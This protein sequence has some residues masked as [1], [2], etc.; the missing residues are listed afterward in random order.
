MCKSN[1]MKCVRRYKCMQKLL[2][3]K[4]RISLSV[5]AVSNANSILFATLIASAGALASKNDTQ[6]TLA[7][8]SDTLLF[9]MQLALKLKFSENISHCIA[10]MYR[11]EPVSTM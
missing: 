2:C 3:F 7:Y 4:A 1:A 5:E 11:I 6:Y 8:I 10:S 9:I